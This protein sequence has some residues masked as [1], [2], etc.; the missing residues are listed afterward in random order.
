[1]TKLTI[2]GC[3]SAKP[4]KG[5]WPSA[6]ILDIRDR[7]FLIDCGEGVQIRMQESGVRTNRLGHIFLSHLHADHCLGLVGLLC[8]WSMLGRTAEVHIHAQPDAERIFKPL[9]DY[10]G[11]GLRFPVLFHSLDPRKHEL[12]Y[13][14]RA[15]EVWSLPL[16][17]RVPCCGYLFKEKPL[18]R[19]LNREMCDANGVPQAYYNLIK[20]GADFT[21]DDG[22]LIPNSQL[23][24]D[25]SPSKSYA[26]CSDTRATK[27][28]LP[29][30]QGV[31]LLYHE[32]TFPHERIARA[33]QT[34]HTTAREAAELAQEA[35]VGQLI[36][37]HYSSSIRDPKILEQ[38]AKAV[39]P[40][41]LAAHDNMTIEF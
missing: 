38:E 16:K 14:D 11:D 9:L 33:R 32:A 3:G 39:F 40:N 30:L 23:T 13:E 5:R 35:Q 18:E 12:V 31:D 24:T 1:M 7:Q 21:R 29:Y 10:F 22:K 28:L 26:Y 6:Q 8:T 34:M 25:P 20:Q 4:L 36:I 2:L 19:H 27:T 15:V 37:G 41:T 17:H